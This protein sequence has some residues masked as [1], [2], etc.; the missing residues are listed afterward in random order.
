[1]K[2]LVADDNK[3]IRTIV[4]KYLTSWGYE[5]LEAV[6]GNEAWTLMTAHDPEIAILYNSTFNWNNGVT[7]NPSQIREIFPPT[8]GNVIARIPDLWLKTRNRI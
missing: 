7:A 2:V 8:D 1:M 5:V 4:R 6:D 3:A